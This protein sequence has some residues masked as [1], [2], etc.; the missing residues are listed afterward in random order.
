[1]SIKTKILEILE[2]SRGEYISGEE[3]AQK[4]SVSRN[5]V[6]KAVKA[7]QDEGYI[8]N[9]ATKKGYCMDNINDILSSQSI[10]KYLHHS[11]SFFDIEVRKNVSSTNDVIK[12]MAAEG[13]QEGKVIVS[14]SQTSGK[15]RS[16][17]SFFSPYGTGIYMSILL[18]PEISASKAFLLTT[19]AAVAAAESIEHISG[20]GIMIKWVN[21]L[22][23]KNKKICGI[24]TEAS[25]SMEN[26]RLEYAVVGIG[27]NI[28]RPTCDF[29]PDIA[30]N[31]SSL[32]DTS[33][34]VPSDIRSRI[35]AETLE[36]FMNFYRE[37]DKKTFLEGYRKRSLL[38][39]RIV[40]LEALGKTE[41]ALVKGIDDDFR[42][43]V[44]SPDGT[45]KA[46]SSGE[47]SIKI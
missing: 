16:G 8:I 10:S 32:Y 3:L 19:S 15:G 40:T 22:Y 36:R 34:K 39:G 9:A 20:R 37:L 33:E 30:E 41:K 42:L 24:L 31:V 44:E 23:Y 47:V 4:L 25:V 27:M 45:K 5:A 13:G 14:E 26:S 35:T 1:M 29:P 7:L 2:N 18:R 6:W 28:Y 21:D 46:I 17:R 38:T 11:G 43:I 12:E